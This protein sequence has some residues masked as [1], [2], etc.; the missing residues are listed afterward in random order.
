[1]SSRP[2][3]PRR[4][5]QLRT[6]LL[7]SSVV[8]LMAAALSGCS[9]TSGT[10]NVT[11]TPPPDR[12]SATK[13]QVPTLPRL[14]RFV[15]PDG[16]DQG[17]GTE[18]Q[19]WRTIGHAFERA[20]SGQLVYVRGGVYHEQIEGIKTHL[21]TPTRPISL[22][23]YPS[24]R[25]VLEG[26]V[27]L[28][29]L[30]YWIVDG[31][32]VTWD[33]AS[34]LPPPRFLV[35]MTGGIGWTWQNSEFWGSPGSANVFVTGQPND[36]P[37]GWSLTNNCLH[38]L[39]PADQ[40]ASNLAIGSMDFGAGPGLVARNV[41]FNSE[42]QQNISIGSGAGAPTRV[43]LRSNTIY[44][45]DQAVT[46]AGHPHG[47]LLSRNLIGGATGRSL[48]RFAHKDSVGTTVR[49]NL[50]VDGNQF[51]YPA[52]APHVHGVGNVVSEQVPG[53]LDTTS[54]KGFVP[55]L[56]AAISYGAHTP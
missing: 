34:T 33:S 50:A 30:S 18:A 27:A 24:E 39:R 56:D 4:V 14:L 9:R 17:P 48:I 7:V 10:G 23:A 31:I 42:G 21:G 19:P 22:V 44:G 28:K 2:P 8:A 1:M 29:G 53:F 37:R 5:G 54:C 40:R 41:I 55:G 11:T 12:T 25:P 15:S 35:K 43:R 16:D 13:I 3:L 38:S 20:Y 26:S 47:L 46:I 36:E 45:G 51:F 6:T 52:V 49:Q 32:N